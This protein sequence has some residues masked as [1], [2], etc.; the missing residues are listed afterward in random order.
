MD[1][2]MNAPNIVS[3]KKR[4]VIIDSKEGERS[5]NTQ[6]VPFSSRQSTLPVIACHCIIKYA[7]K[8]IDDVTMLSVADSSSGA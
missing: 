4:T 7:M 6:H 3:A 5:R 8:K 1:V 2:L